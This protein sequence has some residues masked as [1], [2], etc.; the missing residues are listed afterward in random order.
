MAKAERSRVTK[1]KGNSEGVTIQNIVIRPAV[2]KTQ[3]VG[4]WRSAYQTAIALNP[5]RVPLYDLYTDILLDPVLTGCLCKRI[6]GVT[7]TK[8]SFLNSDGKQVD[9]LVKLIGTKQFRKLR[10]ER[11]LQKFWGITLLELTRINGK[12][13]VY[14]I[15]RKHIKPNIGKV[16]YEQYGQDGI[17]YKEAPYNKYLVQFGNDDDLGLLLKTAPYVVYKR[18]GFGD[19]ANYAEMFGIP[20]REARYDGY[21]DV[22]RKQLEQ[23]LDAVG[24]AQYAILP[25][26]AELTIH[27]M[28]NAQGTG[29]LYDMLRKA[30][31]EEI[32]IGILGQSGTTLQIPGKLGNDTM[33]ANT[34]DDIN[35]DDLADE[36]GDMNEC[37]KPVLHTL[38]YPVKCGRFVILPTKEELSLKE[39]ATILCELKNQLGLPLDDNYLYQEFGITKPK[40]YDA[41]KGEASENDSIEAKLSAQLSQLKKYAKRMKELYG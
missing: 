30:C 27:E 25:K 12:L 22:V 3:D 39:K 10:V 18:G 7:K 38:G 17:N 34:E 16:V 14:S 37:V 36:L 35:I 4:S 8:L 29:M 13:Q 2:V 11:M 20:F 23:A 6:L 21:N 32:S 28:K 26:E 15:P 24:S 19:W 9:E 33:N 41:I 40:N 5:I 1:T 31:N